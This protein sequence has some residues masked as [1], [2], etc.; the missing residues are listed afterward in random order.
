MLLPQIAE[1]NVFTHGGQFDDINTLVEFV[2][3]K[4]LSVEDK[5]PADE[6][7]ANNSSYLQHFNFIQHRS[8]LDEQEYGHSRKLTVG[9]IKIMKLCKL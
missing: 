2:Q 4:M 5:V 1:T 3:Q 7:N 9:K 8:G 6:D